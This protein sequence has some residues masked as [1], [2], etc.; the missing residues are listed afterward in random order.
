M[1]EVTQTEQIVQIKA[2]LGAGAINVLGVPFAG[3]DTVCDKLA[4][5]FGG[6]V[7]SSGQIFRS[8]VAASHVQKEMATG[9]L[10]P[11]DEFFKT[12][13][14][15]FSQASLKAKPLILSSVGKRHGEEAKVQEALATAD[16]PLRAVIYLNIDAAE[17]HKRWEAAQHIG[18][19][20]Q[21]DDDAEHVLETRL[22]VFTAQT[23]PVIDFYRDQ[24]LLLE[25]DGEQSREGVL[26]D[27]LAQLYAQAQK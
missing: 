25:V 1:E 23:V 11:S 17:A 10:L 7:V 27:I 8:K 16:H 24:G 4:E 13:L 21:R 6:V 5:L 26:R 2:W 14:P 12:I 18:D 3:K 20:G 19:R 9:V 15:Y 22:Q